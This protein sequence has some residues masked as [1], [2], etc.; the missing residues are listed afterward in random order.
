MYQIT[1]EFKFSAA[2]HLT[3]VYE[4]HKCARVHGHN[5]TVIVMLEAE[6]LN[7]Q[8][9][10]EDYG[11]L[12]DI[13]EWIDSTFDHRD[14]NDILLVE[15]TAENLAR[16]IY[17]AFKFAHPL[18]TVVKVKETDGTSASYYENL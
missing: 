6:Q 18:M 16:H 11:D 17:D 8:G 14:L 1:K 13:K 3:K 2:H 9:F 10:V 4:G 7:E 15:P 12:R 5:Y